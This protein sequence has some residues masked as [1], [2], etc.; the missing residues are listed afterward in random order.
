M[1][2]SGFQFKKFFIAHDRC[3]MKVNTDG[4]LLGA[5]AE[6]KNAKQILDLGTGTGLIAIMLA[7]RTEENCDITALELEPNAYQQAVENAQHSTWKRRISIKQGDIFESDFPQKF[8]LIVS[9][10]PY[11]RD[12]L[13]SRTAERDLARSLQKSHFDWL[14][15][16]KK[17]LAQTGK[18]SFILPTQEA[19]KLLEQSKKSGLFCTKIYQ[20]I[21]KNGQSPKRLIL[22]FQ[23]EYLDCKIKPLVI[24]NEQNQYTPEFVVLTRDFYLKM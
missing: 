1:K 11:F 15:Q 23:F 3:A 16:A 6:I 8:D 12:S 7:Q 4:I 21:T 9:N 2:K 22:T 13:A 19:E 18:I 14:M 24:Y 20:I 5:M 17:W 10:P